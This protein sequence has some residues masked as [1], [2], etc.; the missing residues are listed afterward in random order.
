MADLSPIQNGSPMSIRQ[1]IMLTARLSLPAIMAQLSTILM[2]Y[3]DAS[4]VGQLGTNP[5]AAVGLVG[6][7]LW[8]FWGVCSAMTVGFTVQVAHKIGARKNDDAKSI[9]RQ[10]FTSA[11]IFSVVITL[12][13]L[14]IAPYLPYWLGGKEEIAGMSTEYFMIFIFM[15]FSYSFRSY[16]IFH[17]PHWN[18]IRYQ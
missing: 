14:A 7:S 2:Q 3:I 4:M 9:L 1:Q 13:G 15:I 11:I 16:I 6:T 10:S 17:I 5:S 8:L 18:K 12:I